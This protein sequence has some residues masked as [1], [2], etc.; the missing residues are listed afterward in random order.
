MAIQGHMTLSYSLLLL[1][2]NAQSG[3]EIWI[4]F[5]KERKYLKMLAT[6]SV[7]K[8]CSANQNTSLGRIWPAGTGLQ[9]LL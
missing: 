1:N 5:F 6:R 2:G 7:I 8:M 4:F 3:L 9:L